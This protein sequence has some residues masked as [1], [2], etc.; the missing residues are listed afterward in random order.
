MVRANFAG[1]IHIGFRFENLVSS[2]LEG[3]LGFLPYS[4]AI[5]STRQE[6]VGR[7]SRRQAI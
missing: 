1:L 3:V 5:S 7:S 2:T 6:K 4:T